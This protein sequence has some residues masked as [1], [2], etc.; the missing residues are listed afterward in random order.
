MSIV[1]QEI[2]RSKSINVM[3]HKGRKAKRGTKDCFFFLATFPGT[4]PRELDYET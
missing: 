4:G 1:L 3:S 2:R